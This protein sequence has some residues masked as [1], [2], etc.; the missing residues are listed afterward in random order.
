MLR[1]ERIKFN[2]LKTENVSKFS[3]Q[4]GMGEREQ[5]REKERELN[6]NCRKTNH[7]IFTSLIIIA[8]CLLLCGQ[9]A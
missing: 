2:C 9:S 3:D 4:R 7:K 1:E 8:A 6:M 5:G